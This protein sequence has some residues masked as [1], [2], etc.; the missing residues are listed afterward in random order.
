[1]L[2]VGNG[3][4][5]HTAVKEAALNVLPKPG[6]LIGD[7]WITDCSG[8]WTRHI[9]P[10]TGKPTVSIPMAGTKEIDEAVE[11]ARAALPIWR[12]MP[13]DQRRELMLRFA[14][15]LRQQ[16]ET[17]GNMAVIENGTPLSIA[18]LIAYVAADLFAYNAG[19]AD[20]IGG[21]VVET[22]PVS[23]LDYTLEEP[24]GVVAAILP[25]NGPVAQFA[26]VI[27]PALAAG[28][29]VVV[30]P[31]SLTPFTAMWFGQLFLEAGFPPGVVNIVP[32]KGKDGDLLCAHP[33]VDKIHLTGSVSTARAVL[34]AAA[35]NLTPC[36]FELGG[37]SATIVFDDA[38]LQVAAQSAVQQLSTLS[39]QVC[40]KGSRF[41]VQSGVYEKVIELCKTFTEDIMVGDP[42]LETTV[43]SPV[44]S[45]AQ[46]DE[47]MG[48]INRAKA[49]KSFRLITGGERLGGELS[50]GYFIA[51]TIFADVENS[52]EICQKEVFGPVLTFTKF[53]TEDQAIRMANDSNY[54]L[55]GYIY[56]NDL[57]R[58]HT[59]SSAIRTGNVWVNNFMGVPAGAP[60]GGIKQSGYGRVGG[61]HG[62][63]EFKRP[64]NIWISL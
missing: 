20:K 11:T 22:W 25:F 55:G 35:L 63:R 7:R 5:H 30:K 36:G 59:V 15:L 6:L 12:G 53:D 18:T 44:I 60:F 8:G 61:I 14:Q 49:N 51:P 43:M 16:V 3:K 47:I 28:N 17:I 57:K 64:K 46:C 52:A 29:C 2:E 34:A 21:E 9:Y 37:K 24:Y 54:G 62:I 13:A 23:A 33:G 41:I 4:T 40:V 48:F 39:G 27:A 26:M 19:W 38:D 31:S 58:A 32:M 10:A 1:M 56:T 42:V 45:A 50:G